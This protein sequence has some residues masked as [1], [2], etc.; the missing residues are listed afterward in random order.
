MISLW[1]TSQERNRTSDGI[2]IFSQE[3][4]EIL[5]VFASVVIAVLGAIFVVKECVLR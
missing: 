4:V 1:L 3:R 5:L 2:H